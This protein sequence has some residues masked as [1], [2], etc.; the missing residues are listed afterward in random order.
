MA[1]ARPLDPRAA[2]AKKINEAN[3]KKKAGQAAGQQRSGMA[4]NRDKAQ[5]RRYATKLASGQAK[6]KVVEAGVASNSIAN[7]LK[8]GL[9]Q[10][11]KSSRTAKRQAENKARIEHL[12]A[13]KRMKDRIERA[14]NG[15]R[16]VWQYGQRYRVE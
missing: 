10:F 2:A 11:S 14:E 6:P 7:I 13:E 3:K 9:K 1:A 16:Y 8:A 15:P 4:A 5:A 12:K